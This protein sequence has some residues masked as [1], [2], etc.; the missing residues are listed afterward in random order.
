MTTSPMVARAMEKFCR[1]IATR[2]NMSNGRTEILEQAN[3]WHTRGMELY[4]FNAGVATKSTYGATN[5]EVEASSP[6]EAARLAISA[7]RR[8]GYR[9]ITRFNRV[10]E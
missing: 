2:P 1:A 9:K 3:D 6:E 5:I 8:A 7:L 10:F 4:R